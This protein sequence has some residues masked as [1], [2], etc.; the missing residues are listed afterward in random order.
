MKI[1][2]N[3]LIV[4]RAIVPFVVVVILFA[5]VGNFGFG[6]IVEI[7]DQIAGAQNEQKIL[8]QKLDILK[9]IQN[10]GA[11]SS[12]LVAIALPDSNPSLS[13]VSQIKT[14]AGSQGVILSQ[15]KTG[16]PTVDATGLSTVSVSF[17]V[18]G[19]MTQIEFF[20]AAISSFSPIS[21]VDKIKVSESAPGTAL[22]NL[23]VRSFWAPFPTKVPAVTSAI[24]DLTPAERE[25]LQGLSSLTQPVFTITPA[26][27]GGRSDPFTQ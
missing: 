12:T 4:I 9:S 20:I 7:R 24:P 16:S 27:Q 3:V 15:M 10:S 19:S 2:E 14:L 8:T 26:G 13:V 6:K 5:I 23:T 1:Q 25:T 18:T 22:A 11:Q 17:G 21:I